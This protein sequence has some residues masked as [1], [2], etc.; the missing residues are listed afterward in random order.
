MSNIHPPDAVP[1]QI[2]R[3]TGEWFLRARAPVRAEVRDRFSWG[4]VD[5]R[6]HRM[7]MAPAPFTAYSSR[8]G[9]AVTAA[10]LPAIPANAQP[11]ADP[12]ACTEN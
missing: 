11:P 12:P 10:E 9:Y 3:Q 8:R 1:R 7:G 4:V 5:G 6:C 2:G